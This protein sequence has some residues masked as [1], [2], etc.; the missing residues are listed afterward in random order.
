MASDAG[1]GSGARRSSA[2]SRTGRKPLAGPPKRRRGYHR[3]I[4]PD[5][6]AELCRRIRTLH[7]VCRDRDMPRSSAMTVAPCR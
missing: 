2:A 1:H 3:A 4:T 6:A 5:I 7:A